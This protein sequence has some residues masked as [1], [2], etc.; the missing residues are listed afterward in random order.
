MFNRKLDGFVPKEIE[1]EV[2]SKL[3]DHFKDY[4]TFTSSGSINGMTNVH[5]LKETK[6]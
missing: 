1:D 5:E 3:F 2:Y 6:K 4:P